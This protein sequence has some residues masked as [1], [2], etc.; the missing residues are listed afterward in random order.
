MKAEEFLKH[1]TNNTDITI[2]DVRTHS[3][4]SQGHMKDALHIDISDSASFQ[5]KIDELDKNKVYALYCGSGY[6]S[7]IA[8]QYMT[9]IGFTDI[10]N[11][12]GG[13]NTGKLP[14]IRN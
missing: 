5:Q 12:E 10:I 13:V 9:Q 8:V 1:Y 4:Y 2:I 14:L 3:E 7:S 11:I 6:R